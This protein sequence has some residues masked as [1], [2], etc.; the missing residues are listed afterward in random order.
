MDFKVTNKLASKK[1]A[2]RTIMPHV[3]WGMVALIILL[4]TGF[5]FGLNAGGTTETINAMSQIMSERASSPQ[6]LR[7]PSGMVQ[8]YLMP[9]GPAQ[10]EWTELSGAEVWTS[11]YPTNSDDPHFILEEIRAEWDGMGLETNVTE[12]GLVAMSHDGLAYLLASE[13]EAGT[14]RLFCWPR[15]GQPEASIDPLVRFAE[16]GLPD[17]PIGAELVDMSQ[18]GGG[19]VFYAYVRGS[20]ESVLSSY[21]RALLLE[22]WEVLDLGKNASSMAPNGDVSMF[23]KGSR[24]V[25]VSG[26]RFDDY[27]T[28]LSL[29]VF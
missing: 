25:M 14:I 24:Q 1:D 16:S 7:N 6:P 28:L 4:P 10:L 13:Q 9:L 21:R 22:S 2:R 23:K 26:S 5:L 17:L 3:Y 19:F 12:Q 18:S 20:E 29:V 15:G 11:A 8:K 27:T